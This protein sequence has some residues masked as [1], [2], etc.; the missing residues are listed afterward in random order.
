ML[1]RDVVMQFSKPM[2]TEWARNKSGRHEI[3]TESKGPILG[4]EGWGEKRGNPPTPTHTTDSLLGNREEEN[5]FGREPRTEQNSKNNAGN[6][7]KAKVRL[8]GIMAHANVLPF[9]A[10]LPCKKM[11]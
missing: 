8:D 1:C 7:V 11:S 9:R 4:E 3:L 10:C 5:Q 2:A 6:N